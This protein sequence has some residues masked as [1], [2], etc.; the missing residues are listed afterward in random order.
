MSLNYVSVVKFSGFR[1]VHLAGLC[2]S[3]GLTHGLLSLAVCMM[4]LGQA[5]LIISFPFQGFQNNM[6]AG[7]H[8]SLF[9]M[10]KILK[11]QFKN[12]INTHNKNFVNV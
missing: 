4:T 10:A 3:A 6:W 1:S 5:K 12:L 8:L 2:S 11:K 7:G 9:I